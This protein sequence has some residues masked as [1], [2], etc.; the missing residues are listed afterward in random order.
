M[1]YIASIALVLLR[2]PLA[3]AL[4]ELDLLS[5]IIQTS[6][7]LSIVAKPSSAYSLGLVATTNNPDETKCVEELTKL[8]EDTNLAEAEDFDSCPMD[9]ETTSST[10]LEVNSDYSTCPA[11][12]KFQLA[13]VAAGGTLGVPFTIDYNCDVNK[14]GIDINVDVSEKNIPICL[15]PSCKGIL[16]DVTQVS[17]EMSE[18][19]AQLMESQFHNAGYS[20]TCSCLQSH[21]R[22]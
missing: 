16:A 10:S 9:F 13:C 12:G 19:S 6:N 21:F 5:Q 3:L 2:S 15:G 7:T 18:L 4:S 17:E 11:S 22:V 1:N 14:N 20:A 8:T